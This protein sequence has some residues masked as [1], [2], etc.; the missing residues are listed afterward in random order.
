MDDGDHEEGTDHDLQTVEQLAPRVLV[1]KGI[2]L[3]DR[4]LYQQVER[5]GKQV[6]CAET[7]TTQ[8]PVHRFN[9]V[10]VLEEIADQKFIFR[11]RLIVEYITIRLHFHHILYLVLLIRIGMHLQFDDPMY[12]RL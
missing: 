10:Y 5:R 2:D 9:G 11:I 4:Q 6:E 12:L 3:R 8:F 7:D 1:E